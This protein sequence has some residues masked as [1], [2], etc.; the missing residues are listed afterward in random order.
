MPE[1]ISFGNK[2]IFDPF[3]AGNGPTNS[4]ISQK[5]WKPEDGHYLRYLEHTSLLETGK[6]L[7]F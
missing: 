1:D 6:F 7:H 3:E 2:E 5:I 4:G